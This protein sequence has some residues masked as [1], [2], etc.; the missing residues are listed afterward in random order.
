MRLCA[1]RKKKMVIEK[2][3]LFGKLLQADKKV[4]LLVMTMCAGKVVGEMTVCGFPNQ[5]TKQKNHIIVC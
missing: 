4:A 1:T 2:S 3:F 5:K